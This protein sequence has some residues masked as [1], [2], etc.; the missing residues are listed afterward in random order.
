MASSA[1]GVT[2]RRIALE[3]LAR[4]DDDGAYANL[5]LSAVLERNDADLS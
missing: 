4:I 1:E 5:V 3:A 2:A